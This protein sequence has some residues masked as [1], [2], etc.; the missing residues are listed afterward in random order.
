MTK[1]QPILGTLTVL[2]L[3]TC[4]WI[5]TATKIGW[6]SD[7]YQNVYG[8]PL[9]TVPTIQ[10]AI[11]DV[12]FGNYQDR[13]TVVRTL[14]FAFVGYLGMKLGPANCHV[15]EGIAHILCGVCLIILL[16]KL[17]WPTSTALWAA[18]FFLTSPWVSEGVFWWSG[19]ATTF[20]ALFM[21]LASLSYVRWSTEER[22]SSFYLYLSLACIFISLCWY[23]LWLSCFLLFWGIETNIQCQRKNCE[24]NL[25][26]A[27]VS[28]RL[29][30]PTLTPSILFVILVKLS[31]YSPP[32]GRHLSSSPLRLMVS[33]VSLHLRVLNWFT[34]IHW[35][36]AVRDGVRVLVTRP[37]GIAVLAA[38]A[39]VF[40]Y[41]SY[42]SRQPGISIM[43]DTPNLGGVRSAPALL[44]GYAFFAASRFV[45][46]LVGGIDTETRH[47]Y[48]AAIGISIVFAVL[49]EI[50][51]RRS[52]KVAQK[53]IVGL[54]GILISVNTLAFA[55]V[56]AH[57]ETTTAYEHETVSMLRP[58]VAA[59][60]VSNSVV[61]VGDPTNSPGEMSYFSEHP[62]WGGWFGAQ[63]ART[64]SD[65]QYYVAK[66]TIHIGDLLRFEEINPDGHSFL[67]IH[68]KSLTLFTWKD[69]K[70]YKTDVVTGMQT[71]LQGQD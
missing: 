60:P 31:A 57:Y 38:V 28:A 33:L 65:L 20:A 6:I 18:A 48:G 24:S 8:T 16:R 13:P 1:L 2:L 40:I 30:W 19:S 36:S 32:A 7:D 56:G 70:L 68:I 67:D 22:K 53:L 58:L 37:E 23:E 66:S 12:G 50:L 54:T 34:N 41:R 45:L 4:V 59:L 39:L 69:Q 9:R 42:L 17:N 64:R 5:A 14:G 71:L 61:I 51:C 29:C 10:Q 43:R 26:V 62:E 46:I 35:T 44:L 47:N 3:G 25:S 49:L 52:S 63:M 27:A 15:I 21:L 55:G 11:R